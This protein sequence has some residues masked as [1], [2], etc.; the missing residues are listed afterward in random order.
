[1]PFDVTPNLPAN[2]AIAKSPDLQVYALGD[3]IDI[4]H[5][6]TDRYGNEIFA[7][8]VMKASTPLTG[9]G[10]TITTP[11]QTFEYNGEGT[12]RVDA[13]VTDPTDGG[14]PVRASV[15]IT[16]NS[17]GPAIVCSNPSDGSML[18]HTPGTNRALNGTAT[19]VSGVTSVRVNGA[20]ATYNA[21]TGA[22]SSNV[23]TRFGINLSLI[24]I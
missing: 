13:T 14:T 18:N 9:V 1:M 7:P 17:I 21:G 24:H 23:T 5:V 22:F 2:I 4:T 19:D 8:N 11:P 10:P 12:Y 20:V 16:V 3:L 15:T 6:V